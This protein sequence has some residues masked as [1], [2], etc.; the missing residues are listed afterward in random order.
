MIEVCPK[1]LGNA[2]EGAI[3]SRSGVNVVSCQSREPIQDTLLMK[4]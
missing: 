4:N 1:P 2:I 3:I